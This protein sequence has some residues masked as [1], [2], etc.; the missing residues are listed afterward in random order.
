M[1]CA[2]AG[3]AQVIAVDNS[4]IIAKAT[5][6]IFN[7]GLADR[8]TCLRGAIEEVKLPVDKVDIIVSEWMG[9]CLLYEAM[10]PSVLYARDKYLKPDGLLV[11]SSATMWIAPVEDVEYVSDTVSFWRDVYGF[12]MVAMQEGIFDDVR[13]EAM[14][15]QS[16]CGAP[17][18]F[19]V[20]DLHTVQPHELEFTAP[21]KSSLTKNID[22]LHGFL[23]WFDN[24]FATARAEPVPK[25]E[26]TPEVFMKAKTGNV[27]FTT[28]P[29][30]TVTHWKQGLLLLPPS[31]APK[32]L[33]V[34][35][36]I[37]GKVTF[38]ALKDNARALKLDLSW[39]IEEDGENESCWT[40]S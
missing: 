8:I 40:L 5:E 21:W 28:G 16:V 25:P 33:S 18:P 15:K 6:N 35:C 3:A 14:S 36:N 2:R 38:A 34:S 30:G 29:S 1:F 37:T 27:A 20:L 10:L 12:D 17:H 39:R 4:D 13:V 22:E 24:F 32:S 19:K 7:N 23:I 31:A 26:T 9:Y 11:P